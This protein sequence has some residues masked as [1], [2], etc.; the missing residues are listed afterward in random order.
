MVQ[1]I[2]A[3]VSKDRHF[4]DEV[5]FPVRV[6]LT[7]ESLTIMLATVYLYR[8]VKIRLTRRFQLL[9]YFLDICF[10]VLLRKKR[11]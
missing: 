9:A 1:W 6:K 2:N 5:L 4:D 10:S 11:N 8:Q 7:L 3:V